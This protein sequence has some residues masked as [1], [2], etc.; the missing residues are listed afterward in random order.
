MLLPKVIDQVKAPPI[1][2]QGIKTKLVKFIGKRIL[3]EGTGKWVEPF[4]GSGVVLF[5]IQPPRAL[6]SDSNKHI[7]KFYQ[8]IQSGRLDEVVAKE[9]LEEN[10]ARLRE[11]G[12]EYYYTIREEFNTYGGSLRFLFLNRASFNGVMRFNSKGGY[13]VPFGH[14][15]NRYRAAYITKI[16]NQIT[17]VRHV[18][19]NNDWIFIVQDFRQTLE[20]CDENDFVYLDPPYIGRHTDYFNKWGEGEAKELAN[21][22]NSLPCGYALSLWLKNKYRLNTH[23]LEY[24]GDNSIAQYAHFYHVGSHEHL[25]NAMI[26][27][28]VT[29]PGYEANGSD[30]L[31]SDIQMNLGYDNDG[32][33]KRNKESTLQNLT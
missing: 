4:L 31:I 32:N 6:V 30:E 11:V 7:I 28:L 8:D 25:R 23:L 26:E 10:G 33:Y 21:L 22:S 17:W 18:I 19:S 12:A 29:K 2:C 3:W 20:Q 14:K 15:P 9:Y 13:N 16:V 1:K 27:A 24:W 5:N